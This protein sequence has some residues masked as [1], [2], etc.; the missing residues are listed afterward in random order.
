MG[1]LQARHQ[2]GWKGK[3]RPC[4]HCPS[5]N[6]RP[7]AEFLSCYQFVQD[8]HRVRENISIFIDA[9]VD[10][11]LPE[12]LLDLPRLKIFLLDNQHSTANRLKDFI[13]N[14][15]DAKR[16]HIIK[17]LEDISK[18]DLVCTV[19]EDLKYRSYLNDEESYLMCNNAIHENNGS[20]LKYKVLKGSE[21][22]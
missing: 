6:N 9:R 19:D 17:E 11:V 10:F 1:S 20:S 12:D 5:G 2:D 22:G 7:P 3:S 4:G 16:L 15:P 14:S 8:L 21:L 18:F 13:K